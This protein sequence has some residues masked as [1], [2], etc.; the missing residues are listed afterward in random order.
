MDEKTLQKAISLQKSITELSQFKDMLRSHIFSIE[1]QLLANF[2]K[3]EYEEDTKIFLKIL[4]HS[5]LGDME[6][7]L[8]YKIL[9]KKNELYGL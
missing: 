6:D 1:R 9:D 4:I 3:K 5:R 7:D 8:F 2:I